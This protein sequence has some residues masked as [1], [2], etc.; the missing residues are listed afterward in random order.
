MRRVAL[1]IILLFIGAFL[2]VKPLYFTTAGRTPLPVELSAPAGDLPTHIDPTGETVLPNGRLITPAGVQV[3]VEPHPYGMALSPDGKMLITANVGTWPYS[4]SVI[5]SLD[6]KRP[7]LQEI[8]PLYPPK[9]SEIE[10]SSV[11]MGLAIAGDNRTAYVSEGDTGVI[12]AYDLYVRHRSQ[13]IRL[14]GEFNGTSY[15]HSFSGALALAP[16]GKLLYAL[17]LAHFE[18]VVIDTRSG[19]VRWRVGVGRLPF[20]L[21]VSPSGEKVYVSNIGTYRYSIVPGFDSRHEESTGLDFAPFG[22]G[23]PEA[24]NGVVIGGKRVPG[25]GDPNTPDSNSVFVLDVKKG[26]PA[27]LARVRTGLAIG[28]KSVGGASPGG[29]AV[30]RDRVYVSNSAQDSISIIDA[31]KSRLIVTTRLEPAASVGGLRGVLPFG[32]TLSPDESRLYVACAG[33]N[34]VAVFDTRYNRVLG[35]IPTGWFP[36][37]VAVSAD[38]RT[39]YVAN[40]K[41]FGAGPNGGQGFMRG[42]AG[43]YI[44]DITKGTVSIIKVPDAAELARMTEKVLRNNG[45]IPQS[46]TDGHSASRPSAASA[47][48]GNI[49]HVIL[50]VKENRSFDEMFGDIRTLEGQAVNG[51][52]N[53]ARWGMDA[54]VHEEGQP[55]LRHVQVTPNQHALAERFGISDNYYVDSD[56]SFDGHHW[57]V[58]SYPTEWLETSWP[59]T[60]GGHA[61]VAYDK[62]APGRLMMGGGSSLLPEDFLE[63]GS[64][65]DHLARHGKTFRNY[66][67]GL[68]GDDDDGY[69]PTGL[70]LGINFPMPGPLFANTCRTYP[71][72]NTSI[73]DQYRY[74]QFKKDFED[75][76]VRGLQ[77]LPQFMYIWLPNDHT[78][79]P[80]PEDGY[81]YRASYV[82]DNDLALGKIIDLL[83]HSKFWA[84]TAVFITE[85][86]AQNG[87]DHVDAHRS[88]LLVVSPYSRRAV[89]HVH[90]SM[91]SILKTTELIL[92]I[93]PL[94]QYDAAATALSDCFTDI[95]DVTP[96]V[97]LPS[98]T[99]IFDPEKARDPLYDEEHGKPLPPSESLDNPSRIR[100]EMEKDK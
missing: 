82:A 45:F 19:Q 69:E 54:D 66:G 34:A 37:R 90:T 21:A 7:D 12:D 44:G 59:P 41:G 71:M 23:S 32:L 15:R 13:V 64:L 95:P 52:P 14:D 94:N 38:G 76:Y 51:D 75:R 68:T 33:I 6:S 27:L 83:S 42:P 49:H 98:D 70:R 55:D 84:D 67:E 39:L 56:V 36:A 29:V 96:Y 92:G 30:G 46:S 4:L 91:L 20:A 24:Q 72:F 40:G 11:Y 43:D 58:D 22:T 65:W 48:W 3:V 17:D 89:S 28:A 5:R 2:I 53:L 73:P 60:Y 50:I 31:R 99:S 47:P 1:L 16:D 79:K 81:A 78:A 86:D 74:E 57:L 100:Q 10:P 63:A 77:P 18:L 35:Y 97:F 88:L 61:H 85:D 8:P 87:R 26:P 62:D 9:N 80:R 25:L 93:P